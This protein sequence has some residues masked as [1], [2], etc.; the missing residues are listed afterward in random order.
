MTKLADLNPQPGDVLRCVYRPDSQGIY[1]RKGKS[2][3]IEEDGAMY[4]DDGFRWDSTKW[5]LA[6]SFSVVSRANEEPA[7]ETASTTNAPNAIDFL[8]DVQE[9]ARQHGY[10]IDACAADEDG[11][12]ISLKASGA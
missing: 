3:T 5:P 4:D 12:S 7:I 11:V 6:P 9:V 8:A 2:Y 10:E 1:W